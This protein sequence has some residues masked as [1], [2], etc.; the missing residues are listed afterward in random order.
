MVTW[1][2]VRVKVITEGSLNHCEYEISMQ[3]GKDKKMRGHPGRLFQVLYLMMLRN[4]QLE[5]PGKLNRWQCHLEIPTHRETFQLNA[6]LMNQ[7]SEVN[8]FRQCVIFLLTQKYFKT[9]LQRI[10]RMIK[11]GIIFSNDVCHIR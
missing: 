11:Y 4:I 5:L 8:W 2:A 3:Q 6:F 1:L 10:S 7:V 9:R